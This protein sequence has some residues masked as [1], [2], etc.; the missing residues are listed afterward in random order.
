MLRLTHNHRPESDCY[1]AAMQK[2][3]DAALR[4]PFNIQKAKGLCY[5]WMWIRV[6]RH[7]I[8][9]M[10]ARQDRRHKLGCKQS[11]Q[12]FPHSDQVSFSLSKAHFRIFV[13]FLLATVSMPILCCERRPCCHLQRSSLAQLCCQDSTV[14]FANL[15]VV[16][17]CFTQLWSKKWCSDSFEEFAFDSQST[18]SM[19]SFSGFLEFIHASSHPLPSAVWCLWLRQEVLRQANE[20]A[21]LSSHPDHPWSQVSKNSK[22]QAANMKHPKKPRNGR[23]KT[24]PHSVAWVMLRY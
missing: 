18:S 14:S 10:S 17:Q 22:S 13:R 1:P 24:W 19:P 6:G 12:Q 2:W 7:K 4:L 23:V 20:A 5:L 3:F 9:R 11:C 15:W 16:L 21:F 8:L